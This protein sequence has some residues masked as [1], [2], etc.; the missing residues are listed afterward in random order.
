MPTRRR[1]LLRGIDS[2]QC[3]KVVLTNQMRN[4]ESWKISKKKRKTIILYKNISYIFAL[5]FFS[6]TLRYQD[7]SQT[8]A[9]CHFLADGTVKISPILICPVSPILPLV[10][11]V[12]S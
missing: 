1:K 8:S 12:L 9:G 4:P 3:L 6:P 11:T 5:I 7:M 2:I 10:P